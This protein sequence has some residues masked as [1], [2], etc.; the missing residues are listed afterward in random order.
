MALETKNKKKYKDLI[1]VLIMI[2]ILILYAYYESNRPK[3]IGCPP[4]S[5]VQYEEIDI[6]LF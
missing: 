2:A 5:E 4:V 1:I 6:L 3:N